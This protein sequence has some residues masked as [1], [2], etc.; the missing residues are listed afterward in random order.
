MP[1]EVDLWVRGAKADFQAAIHRGAC[2]SDLP[3]MCSQ[4]EDMVQSIA[5][6]LNGLAETLQL[7][8]DR[9]DQIDR[10]VQT[11][12]ALQQDQPMQQKSRAQCAAVR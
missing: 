8:S 11:Q 2:I 12:Q 3:S 1:N 10:W 7:M 9:I 5:L 6:G 4:I